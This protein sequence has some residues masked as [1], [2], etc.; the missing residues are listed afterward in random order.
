MNGEYIL[1]Y[2]S[3]FDI[4]FVIFIIPAILFSLFF[5][6]RVNTVF[7]RYSRVISYS[8]LTGAQAALQVARAGEALYT[9]VEPVAGRLSDHYDPRGNVIR[10]SGNVYESTS[11]AAIGVAAHEAGHAIQHAQGYAPIKL[12]SALIPVTQIASTLTTPLIL[13]GIFFSFSVLINIGIAMFTIAFLFQAVSLP[14]EYNASRRALLILGS[15][16]M[17]DENEL[18]IV[19]K[20]LSAAAMTYVASM[21]LALVQLVRLVL[22]SGR[23]R[24]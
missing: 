15:R 10:L 7:N 20:V 14:A 23:R 12:R 9:C 17:L 8:G 11:I 16:N 24:G 19:K 18:L 6:L 2:Y 3:E 4:Y 21:V 1:L 13:A 5:Q 22:L